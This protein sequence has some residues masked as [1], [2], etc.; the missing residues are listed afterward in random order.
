MRKIMVGLGAAVLLGG[1]LVGSGFAAS[2]TGTQDLDA[3]LASSITLS[4]SSP[5]VGFALPSS[6]TTN[7]PS[8]SATVTANSPYT[9]TVVSDGTALRQW[10]GTAYV[11]AGKALATAPSLAVA[12]SSGTGVAGAGGPV[13]NAAPTAVATGLGGGTDVFGL[14]VSQA[15]TVAD[16]P[17]PSGHTYHARFTYTAANSI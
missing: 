17:L 8:G 3:T 12:S 11:A 2:T 10:D 1:V 9:V 16:T 14:T 13:T 7:V 5:N 6:G 15:T 4:L